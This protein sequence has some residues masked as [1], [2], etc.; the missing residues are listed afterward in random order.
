M[1]NNMT[2]Y[3]LPSGPFRHSY[4]FYTVTFSISVTIAI[5][6]PVAV[7]GNALVLVAIWRNLIL[8]TPSYILIAGLAFTDLCTGLITEPFYVASSLIFLLKPQLII[9]QNPP[10]FYRVFGIITSIS[11]KYFYQA[12]LLMVTLMSVERWL[13][14]SRRSVMTV[15]RAC[16]FVIIQFIIAIPLVLFGHELVSALAYYAT[17]ISLLLVCIIVTSV[18]YFN[19]FRI[20]RRH[21]QQIHGNASSQNFAQPAINIDKYKKSIFSILYILSVFYL[22]FLPLT[23]SFVLVVVL[24]RKFPVLLLEVSS[25]LVLLSSSLNPVLYLWRMKDIRDEV[26]RL[27]KRI[28]HRDN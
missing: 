22:G 6:S 5:L 25:M 27:I 4:A 16:F 17:S 19:I 10:T 28:F 3:S 7:V 15:R 12:S 26:K 11:S 24:K 9:V 1:Y 23:I 14:M 20:I 13:H 18:A 2:N 8:R 21:Q